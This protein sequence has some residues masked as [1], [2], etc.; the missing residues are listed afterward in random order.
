MNLLL[1]PYAFCSALKGAR[2]QAFDRVF[3]GNSRSAITSFLF[4]PS[5]PGRPVKM[6]RCISRRPFSCPAV[7]YLPAFPL[8]LSSPLIT[9]SAQ[10]LS[11]GLLSV[12]IVLF[13]RLWVYIDFMTVSF[14]H[15]LLFSF[16]FFIHPFFSPT[17][18]SQHGQAWPSHTR[19]PLVVPSTTTYFCPFLAGW[20]SDQPCVFVYLSFPPCS[21]LV[22]MMPRG[23]VVLFCFFFL[24]CSS[25]CP[26]FLLVNSFIYFFT[27]FFLLFLPTA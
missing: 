21:P 12:M 27:F 13:S 7:L 6:S 14:I 24:V 19:T 17:H 20:R 25:L 5:P 16:L 18:L 4:L 2:A 26:F 11:P 15:I 8:L 22:T 1:S 10:P 9:G 23:S 3:L